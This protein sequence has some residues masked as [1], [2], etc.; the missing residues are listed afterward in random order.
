MKPLISIIIP[1]YNVE[2]YIAKCLDSI[3]NQTFQNYE[4]IIVD[5][6]STDNTLEIIN[7]YISKRFRVFSQKN[8]GAGEARNTGIKKAIGK[9]ITFVDSDDFYYRNDCLEKIA[10]EIKKNDSEVIT[11]KMVR[12]YQNSGK[13][14]EEDDIGVNKQYETEEYLTYTI[15]KSRLSISPCDKIIRKD[16]ID[17]NKIYFPSIK[18]LED[19]DWSMRLYE[20]VQSVSIIN[21]PIYVYR[22]QRNGS[23]T[24]QYTP[25]KVSTGITFIKDWCERC[26]KANHAYSE[27]YLNYIAYQYIILLSVTNRKNSDEHI[28]SELKEYKWLLEYDLNFKTK[29]ARRLYNLFGFSGMRL[30]LKIY[31]FLKNKNIML[32][33]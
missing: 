12:F 2:K 32:I 3:K 31:T 11:Y 19:I 4:V 24:F 15:E 14:L 16:I 33:R 28:K 6:G 22:K 1:A 25:E 17:K 8:K 18:M 5:D 9:Y 23:T 26:K 10:N 27:L 20:H 29:M 7:Q 30:V 13:Y 21:E